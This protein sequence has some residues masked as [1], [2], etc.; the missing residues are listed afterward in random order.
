MIS[1]ARLIRKLAHGPLGWT[2]SALLF[3][4][5]ALADLT[6]GP[7]RDAALADV[8]DMVASSSGD[9]GLAVAVTDRSGV[10]LVATHGYADIKTH[11]RV[12]PDTL[13]AIGSISKSFAAVTLLELNDEGRFDPTAPIARY[14]PELKIRSSFP[15]ITGHALLSHSAGLPNYMTNVASMRQVVGA[16][17]DFTPSYA[18][19]T[20]FWYSN[21][22]YQLLGYA[23]EHIERRPYP[24]ILQRRI[25][26]RLKMTAS[27]P[28]IDTSLRPVMAVSYEQSPID[29]RLV[30]APW[31]DYL[32][33]DGG[34]VSDASDMA[35]YGRMLLNRGAIPGGRLI[36][37]QAFTRLTTPAIEDYGYGFRLSD[38]D[39]GLIVSH[40]GSIA[41]FNAHLEAHVGKGFAVAFLGNARLDHDLVDR[42]IARLSMAAG[43]HAKGAQAR[44]EASPPY[45]V[46]DGAAFVGRFVD[47]G[48]LSLTFVADKAGHLVLQEKGASLPLTKIGRDSYGIFLTDAGPR[49]FTFFRNQG[50]SGAVTDVS[51]GAHSYTKSGIVP[52]SA[53]A[54]F[55][56][57]VGRYKAHGEEGPEVRVFVRRGHLMIAAVGVEPDVQDLERIGPDEFRLAA[58][59]FAPERLRFDGM[60]DGEAQRL[61]YSGVPLY[62]IDLP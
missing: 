34:V 6:P 12:E 57:L 30:E 38:K 55:E 27:H 16:L 59:P 35:A 44:G 25:F 54:G 19:G 31:F 62:R 58:A 29:G 49:S 32:A 10:V 1:M 26:D 9:Q 47:E 8:R 28:Q 50:A 52:V 24:I 53:P 3:S 39:D 43:G 56:R 15:A 18:S 23:A 45:G 37:K 20:H 41:G 13:F 46:A 40:S 11:K 42:I 60:I 7:V 51:S 21:T 36:S 14:I 48:S 17:E 33:A 22:G 61:T 2:A 5:P 4:S